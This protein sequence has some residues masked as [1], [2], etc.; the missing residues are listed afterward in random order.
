MP[1]SQW[2]AADEADHGTAPTPIHPQ[3]DWPFNVIYSSGTTG[4]PKGIVQSW[5]MRWAHVQRAI[6]NGYGPDAVS[7]C[8]TPLYSNTTLVA[9]SEEHTSELQSPCN[10]VCRLLLEK[11]QALDFEYL[12]RDA[13]MSRHAQCRT[14]AST[15]R[16]QAPDTRYQHQCPRLWGRS[17]WPNLCHRPAD[18][19]G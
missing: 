15:T 14:V 8:A 6:H 4:V 1:W 17:T 11:K 7:L 16:M 13:R 2:L 19:T 12:Y 5:A 3:P 9:R 10:L 18:L